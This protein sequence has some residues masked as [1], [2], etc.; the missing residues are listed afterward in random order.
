VKWL[1]HLI[2]WRGKSQ[3]SVRVMPQVA[4]LHSYNNHTYK[5]YM[6]L[7]LHLVFSFL[8]WAETRVIS[9]ERRLNLEGYYGSSEYNENVFMKKLF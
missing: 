3:L 8:V 2:V 4:Y 6:K 7:K 5:V 1:F 9:T